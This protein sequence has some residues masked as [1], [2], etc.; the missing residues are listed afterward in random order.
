MKEDKT[1]KK[2]K[3]RVNSIDSLVSIVA[4]NEDVV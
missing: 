3:M 1:K 4:W 2:R